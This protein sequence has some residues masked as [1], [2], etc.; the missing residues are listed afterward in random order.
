MRVSEIKEL[1]AEYSDNDE[2]M[3]AWNTKEGFTDS[4]EVWKEACYI[5]DFAMLEGFADD[6]RWAISE[7]EYKFLK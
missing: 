5:Y 2:L 3:I 1:L 7:A 6:C 4:D